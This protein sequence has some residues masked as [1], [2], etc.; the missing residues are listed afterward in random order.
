ME[1]LYFQPSRTH[2]TSVQFEPDGD[3]ITADSDGEI[4]HERL[5]ICF[6]NFTT[7]WILQVSL[8]FT[9]LMLTEHILYEW[10]LRRITKALVVWSCCRKELCCLVVKE[11]ERLR[12]G[13]RCKTTRK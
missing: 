6:T 13:T 11:I 9:P 4:I 5:S 2:V 3:V 10:S 7:A 1:I 8:L 12:L